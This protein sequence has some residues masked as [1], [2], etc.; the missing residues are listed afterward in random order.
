MNYCEVR[1]FQSIN[2]KW[3]YAEQNYVK[4]LFAGEDNIF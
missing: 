2:R 3:Y 4:S 1:A